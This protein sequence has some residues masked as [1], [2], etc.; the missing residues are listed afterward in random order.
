M[1][2]TYTCLRAKGLAVGIAGKCGAVA[3]PRGGVQHAVQ[4]PCPPDGARRQPF[5]QNGWP[6]VAHVLW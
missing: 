3:L 6:R 5:A 4:G 1:G 2:K